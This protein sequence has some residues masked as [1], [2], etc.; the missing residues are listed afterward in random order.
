MVLGFLL[1]LGPL[2]VVH[3]L[4][5]YVVARWFGVKVDAFSVGFGKELAGWTDN[6]GTRWKL[7]ALPLGGYVQFAGDMNAVP[8]FQSRMPTARPP[9]DESGWLRSPVRQRP[10][11]HAGQRRHRNSTMKIPTDHNRAESKF[12]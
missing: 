12:A 11:M 8:P 10:G 9:A 6:R 7:S 2:V 3:E 1:V 5:H 4:G